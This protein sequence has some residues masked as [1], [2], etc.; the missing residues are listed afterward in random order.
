MRRKLEELLASMEAT[1]VRA[2]Q[3]AKLL[4]GSPS[5]GVSHTL[6]DDEDTLTLVVDANSDVIQSQATEELELPEPTLLDNT[7]R[8]ERRGILGRGGMGEVRLVH[9]HN[10]GRNVAMKILRADR[11]RQPGSLNRL[12]REARATSQLEHPG[13]VPI[14]DIGASDK[15]HP[16]FTTRVVHGTTMSERLIEVHQAS[17]D[18]QWNSAP[19]GWNFRRLVGVL[20]TVCETMAYAHNNGVIHRDLKPD[21]IMLGEFGEVFVMD[22]GLVKQTAALH[23]KNTLNEEEWI[24]AEITQAGVISGTPAYM[25][26]EQA[27]GD[28]DLLGP[29][30]DVYAL[31]SILYKVLTGRPPYSGG[32]MLSILRQVDVGPPPHPSEIANCPLPD[33]LIRVCLKAMCRKPLDR[34]PNAAGMAQDLAEWLEGAR[35]RERAES[36]L[37]QALISQKRA[38]ELEVEAQRVAKEGQRM[39]TFVDS[40]EESDEKLE[41]WALEDQSEELE[42]Q[43]MLAWSQCVEELTTALSHHRDLHEAKQMLANYYRRCHETAEREGKP[44]E[45]KRMERLIRHYDR[46]KHVEYLRGT[47]RIQ[48]QVN[49]ENVTMSLARFQPQRRQLV[50]CPLREISGDSL[51]SDLPMGSYLLEVRAPDRVTVR[52]PFFI[53]RGEAWTGGPNKPAQ[54]HLP[55]ANQIGSGECFIPAGWC[56]VGGAPEAIESRPLE[57]HWLPDFVMR[58]DPVTNGEYLQFLNHLVD[59]NREREALAHAPKEMSRP[60]TQDARLL[61]DRTRSGRFLLAADQP[62][63]G[64]KQPVVMVSWYAAQAYAQWVSTQTGQAW[65]I[66]TELEWEK[67]ARGADRRSFPCGD[68]LDTSWACTRGSHRRR[69]S[70]RDIDQFPTDIS[71]YGVRGLAGNV[72]DWCT[73]TFRQQSLNHDETQVSYSHAQIR[74][75]T[76]VTDERVLRGGHWRGSRRRAHCS[77]RSPQEASLASSAVGFRLVR[78]L[79]AEE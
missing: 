64:L 72:S 54:I 25:P 70:T 51:D 74:P 38:Q 50:P 3:L 20:H 71:V 33:D 69:P 39:A 35:S 13:I 58:R 28:N 79:T 6:S 16:Y 4:N 8:Y 2:Q 10:L 15:G 34:Y 63:W 78:H 73:D 60:G 47:G 42:E 45:A 52:Y 61:W 14:Y 40:H 67:A 22:W 66:P 55:R 57:R 48:V 19:S 37:A 62:L 77:S 36:L 65:R 31:G 53:R 29:H 59:H 43:A 9:D 46:G 7:Q 17:V 56:W 32:N 24:A 41:V 21:N 68:F 12:L 27:R 76:S 30:T 11:L 44:S 49:A 18:G 23:E 75:K 1:D 26:P 5:E